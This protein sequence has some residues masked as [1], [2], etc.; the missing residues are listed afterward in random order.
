MLV[1]YPFGDVLRTIGMSKRMSRFKPKV[2][3][4]YEAYQVQVVTD[5]DI[6]IGLTA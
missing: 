4:L 6:F 3:V 2:P 1:D 5:P